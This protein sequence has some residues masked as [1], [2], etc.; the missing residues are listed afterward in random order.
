[1][2]KSIN[3]KT[4][5]ESL[6]A[7]VSGSVTASEL[8]IGNYLN[9][10]V[11]GVLLADEIHIVEPTTLMILQGSIDNRGIIFKPILL[12]EEWLL[13]FG[14]SKTRDNFYRKNESIMIEILFHDK[15]V[16]IT[17]QS[18]CLNHIKSVHQLQNLYSVLTGSVLQDVNLTDR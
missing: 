11:S 9:P 7:S 8:R 4:I 14:F 2:D 16:L 17:N 18:V 12:T 1:M 13:K 15:G 3:T 10:E 5:P 6:V